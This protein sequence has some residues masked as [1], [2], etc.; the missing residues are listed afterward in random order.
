MI[1]FITA[2]ILIILVMISTIFGL[3]TVVDLG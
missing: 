3:Q 2:K 1:S